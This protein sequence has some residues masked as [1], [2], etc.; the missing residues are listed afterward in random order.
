M[1]RALYLT[2]LG[3]NMLTC[4]VLFWPWALPRETISGLMGRK[5]M[6]GWWLAKGAEALIDALHWWEPDHCYVT[7]VLENEARRRLYP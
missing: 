2:Y 3:L 7:F 4:A 5:S 6:E 1:G